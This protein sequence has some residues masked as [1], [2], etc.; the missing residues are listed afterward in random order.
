MIKGLY[1]AIAIIAACGSACAQTIV[2]QS[3]ISEVS[4]TLIDVIKSDY[5]F[6]AK[7]QEIAQALSELQQSGQYDNALTYEAFA[8][9]LTQDLVTL[10][11]DKH[12]KVNYNPGFIANR[13]SDEA[14]LQSSSD[15][16]TTESDEAAFDWDLWY[17]QRENYG[18]QRLEILDGNIGFIRLNFFHPLNWSKGAI[19]TA[20]EFVSD[21]E[22]L[23]IDLR[24]NNGGY[25]PSDAYIA[26]YFF[27]EGGGVWDTSYE[28]RTG[29]RETTS[30]FEEVN[31]D[32]Y[33]NKPV[34]VLISDQTFS[35]GEQ[36]A[37]G[38]KHFGKA[39][40]VGQTSAGAAHSIDI[41]KLSE[42]FFVQVPISHGIHPVTQKDWEGVGVIPDIATSP[43]DALVI[44]HKEALEA[45]IRAETRDGVRKMYERARDKLPVI[46]DPK[47]VED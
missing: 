10:S 16:E 7:G 29:E 44:A 28:R 24:T 34:Y 23:L 26:S 9:A 31:G 5:V 19:D 21:T 45:L 15:E 8:D 37:Y 42:N 47:E 2:T 35:L 12:F 46:S 6:E 4:N 25:S 41:A 3:E 18:F 22:A 20:M 14:E 36:L 43:E 13:W 39:T 40:L 1:G 38:M 30:L 17:A 32:K 33:L 11:G 27:E